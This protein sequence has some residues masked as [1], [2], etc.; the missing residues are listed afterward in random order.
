MVCLLSLSVCGVKTYQSSESYTTLVT[1]NRPQHY[2]KTADMADDTVPSLE[3]FPVEESPAANITSV[4]IKLLPWI[5]NC[6]LHRLRPSFALEASAYHG[7]SSTTLSH[8][9]ATEVRNLLLHSPT[10]HPY[11]TLKEQLTKRTSDS[12]QCQIKEL[13]SAEEIGDRKP[14]QVLRRIQQ[15]VGGMAATMDNKSPLRFRKSRMC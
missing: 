14:T 6:G 13:L 1:L 15:P 5:R 2:Y 7:Q 12:E 9:F 4:Q 8:T 11:E 10:E 3:E